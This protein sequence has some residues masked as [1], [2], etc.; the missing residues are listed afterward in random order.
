[1]YYHIAIES[2][3]KFSVL[4]IVKVCVMSVVLH[5]LLYLLFGGFFCIINLL[6]ISNLHIHL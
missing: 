5:T 1:M 2:K 6:K 3:E 4:K